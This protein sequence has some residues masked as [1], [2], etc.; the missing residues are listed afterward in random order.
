M[1]MKRMK[2]MLTLL[3]AVA[4]A[5]GAIASKKLKA[6]CEN[7]QQYTYVSGMGYIMASDDY[8]CI[9]GS[10]ANCTY[11]LSNT[12]PLTYTVCTWGL[13]SDPAK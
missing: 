12:A 6:P 5:A 1:K 9:N 13:Y 2:V 4:G 11:Y 8:Y 3:V 10:S 7:E